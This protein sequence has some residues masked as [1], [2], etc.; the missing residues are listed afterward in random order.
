VR[1]RLGTLAA[2]LVLAATAVLASGCSASLD[3]VAQ[4]ATRTSD[5]STLRFTM[6]M[7]LQLPS[8]A[9][10]MPFTVKGAIDSSAHRMQL[11]MD[12]SKAAALAGESDLVGRM[13]IVEDGL[14]MY[15]SSSVFGR[16]LPGGKSWIR[17]DLTKMAGLSGFDLSALTSGPTD[18]RASLEQLRKAGNVVKI[19]PQK[20]G[21]VATTRYSV[22]VDL[23]Q[24]LDKLGEAQRAAMEQVLDRLESAGGRY[25]PADAWVDADGYLRRFKMAIPNYLGSGSSVS[26]T[27]S[28]F[29]FGDA[30]NIA[31]PPVEQVVD[32]TDRLSSLS[33]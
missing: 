22:L 7:K 25:V 3:P 33:R 6:N 5:V 1:L 24:G 15:V 17:L 11:S 18:P 12:L 13:T 2:L 20:V 28:L 14:V 16:M 4:A 21:G 19:G 26:L 27:M 30:V 31:V 23:R 9:Q 32:L 29:G 8:V 10:A